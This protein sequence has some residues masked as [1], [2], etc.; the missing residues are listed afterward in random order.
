MTE[1]TDPER[2]LEQHATDVE[3]LIWGHCLILNRLTPHRLGIVARAR[4]GEV[5]RRQICEAEIRGGEERRVLQPPR[6]I[7]GASPGAS[8]VSR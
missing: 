8:S 5:G 2:P 7:C 3:Y 4:L 6:T 1:A